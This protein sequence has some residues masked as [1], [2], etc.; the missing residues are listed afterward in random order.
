MQI[1]ISSTLDNIFHRKLINIKAVKGSSQG[2]PNIESVWIFQVNKVDDCISLWEAHELEVCES[3]STV[4][5]NNFI[6]IV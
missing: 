1:S 2:C 4:A 3:F 6:D 5:E